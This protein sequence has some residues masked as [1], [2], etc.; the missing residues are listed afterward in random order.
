MCVLIASQPTPKVTILAARRI[1]RQRRGNQLRQTLKFAVKFGS[2]QRKE[3]ASVASLNSA[4]LHR[5]S[6]SLCLCLGCCAGHRFDGSICCCRSCALMSR[7]LVSFFFS[8]SLDDLMAGKVTLLTS[9]C[10]LCWRALERH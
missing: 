4:L 2:R 9:D 5:L 1:R 10:P 8:L 3:V 6:I 7:E